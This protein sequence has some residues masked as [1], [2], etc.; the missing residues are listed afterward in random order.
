MSLSFTHSY[1]IRYLL[2]PCLISAYTSV[3]SIQTFDAL[4][5]D[6]K[7]ARNGKPIISRGSGGRSSRTGY[8]ATVFGAAGFLGSHLVARLAKHG[9]ITV[10]P[11]REEMKKRHLKVAGDLGVVNFLEFDLRNIKSIEDSVKHSDIVFNLIGREYETKNFSYHDVHV[12]GA[13]RVA[14]AVEKFNVPRL[15]HV[16]AFNADINSPSVF[17]QTKALGEKIVREIVPDA[18]IV[19]P[20]PMYG[21]GDKFL[22]KIAA[23]T[24][25]FTSNENKELIRPVNVVDVAAALERIGYDDATAGKTFELFGPEEMTMA[26]VHELVQNATN[27]EIRQFNL[28]KK[29]H[30]AFAAATQYIYWPTLCP[31]QIER[32][33]IN[34]VVDKNASTFADLGIQPAQLEK[35]V[36]KYV[37]HW[38][39][40]LH[41]NDTVDTTNAQRKDREYIHVID[42]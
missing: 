28:P 13:K 5:A 12:E 16:S 11:Y 2:F 3:R 34:Q 1:S 20:S 35:L 40:Y 36:I 42:Q 27:T 22:N 21:N 8:T 39:N 32:M 15:V 7:I 24:R 37:R 23:Q 18:T 4:T 38:R 30:Q 6:I 14:E 41:L 9:T 31:D 19:R 25:V 10:V 26:A 17:N 29:L 33:F